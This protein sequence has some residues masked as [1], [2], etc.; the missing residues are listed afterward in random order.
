MWTLSQNLRSDV[1]TAFLSASIIMVISVRQRSQYLAPA[2]QTL[3]FF[4]ILHF[5][6]NLALLSLKNHTYLLE[7]VEYVKIH[8][9]NSYLLLF[10]CRRLQKP[11]R[12]VHVH[13]PNGDVFPFE[14]CHIIIAAGAESGHIANLAGM[15]IGKVIFFYQNKKWYFV[16]KIVLTYCE[17]KIVLV[18]E[19]NF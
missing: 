5:R 9:K 17:K 12:E 15:G 1:E 13:L 7:Y 2:E 6:S 14:T 3:A 18:I 4:F 10:F 19:K 16:T 11:A 8:I